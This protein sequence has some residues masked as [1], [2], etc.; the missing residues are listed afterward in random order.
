MFASLRGA[1]TRRTNGSA[2]SKPRRRASLLRS[3]EAMEDRTLMSQLGVISA[4]GIGSDNL[5]IGGSANFWYSTYNSHN[6]YNKIGSTAIDNQGDIYI[7]GE[8]AGKANFDP[9]GGAAGRRATPNGEFEM[10]V[11]KYSPK[12]ALIWVDVFGPPPNQAGSASYPVDFANGLAVDNNGN[13]YAT[14]SFAEQVNFNPDPNGTPHNVTPLIPIFTPGARPPF[15]ESDIFVLKLG[16]D[17]SFQTANHYGDDTHLQGA[18]GPLGFGEGTSV[19]VDPSGNNI[20]VVGDFVNTINFDPSDTTGQG[21][22]T[23]RFT[24]VQDG[25]ALELNSNLSFNWVTQLS[26]STTFG[27]TGETPAGITSAAFD[28]RNDKVYIA[29]FYGVDSAGNQ[30]AFLGRINTAGTTEAT[31]SIGDQENW[32]NGINNGSFYDAV[33]GVAVD[34]QGNVYVTGNFAGKGVNFNDS[35]GSIVLDSSQDG[36]QEDAFLAKYTSNLALLWADRLGSGNA[37]QPV[38]S[39]GLAIDSAND[40]FFGGIF[41]ADASYGTSPSA[42]IV[43][44]TTVPNSQG[45]QSYALRVDARTGNVG[46]TGG[47]PDVFAAGSSNFNTQVFDLAGNAQGQVAFAGYYDGNSTP[48]FGSTTLPSLGASNAFFAELTRP[49]QTQPPP[50]SWTDTGGHLTSIAAGQGEVFGIAADQSIWI[51]S[52]A[53]SWTNTGGHGQSIAV[54]TDGSGHD[55]MWVV[56]GDYSIWRYDQGSWFCTQGWLKSITA[57]HG[58]VFGLGGDDSLWVYNDAYGWT[59]TGGHGQSIALGTDGSGHDELWV[60]AM[61]DSSW[62]YD[63][64]SWFDCGGHLTSMVAGHGEVFGFGSD[65]SLWICSASTGWTNTLGYGIGAAV[66]S[67]ST[68]LDELWLL[69]PS[70][71]LLRHK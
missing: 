19:A 20:V 58:E 12:G 29:G 52:D 21:R 8:F 54:G 11:A 27:V 25:F 38:T 69:D 49:N 23:S 48:S 46:D 36:Q 50:T 59:D 17:G 33:N 65:Q 37:N 3:F 62:C 64:G 66:G 70:N 60:V 32:V 31:L 10:Y 55:E 39:V 53:G 30:D 4:N 5:Y 28:P 68:G 71:R 57:G 41:Q 1:L 15:Y 24:D 40:V 9:Q 16:S 47:T 22:L 61:D 43:L 44:N 18:S 2:R 45:L 34:G 56:G 42:P 7:T 26:S 63:Q 67:D 14:G 13:V 6:N 35:G 51:C